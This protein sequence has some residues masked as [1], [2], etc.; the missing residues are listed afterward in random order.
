MTLGKICELYHQKYGE[1]N[2]QFTVLLWRLGKLRW[3]FIAYKVLYNIKDDYIFTRHS[4]N[5]L[6]VVGAQ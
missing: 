6:D 3:S 2:A 1:N 4:T 5:A